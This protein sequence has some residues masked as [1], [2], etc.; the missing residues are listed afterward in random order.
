LLNY[1]HLY[2]FHVTATEGSVARAAERLDVGQ[3]TVS[4]QVR[5]L[6]RSLATPLFERTGGKLRLTDAGRQAYEHTSIMFRAGER[7]VKSLVGVKQP[8]PIT[9][10]VGI[11]VGVGRV[12]ATDLLKPLFALE[13]CVPSIRC[14]E[15]ADLLRELRSHDLDLLLSESDPG[16][17]ARPDMQ[18]VAIDHTR[19][20]AITSA[21]QDPQAS[22]A[23]S[24]LVHYRPSSP[25]RFAIDSYLDD[26]NLH[27]R[28]AAETDDALVML[29]AVV[30][31]GFLAFVPKAIAREAVASGKVRV[32]AQLAVDA[33]FYALYHD[34]ESSMIARH[35]VELLVDCARQLA[36]D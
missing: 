30:R 6:E 24:A 10:R 27:P 8:P 26:K 18:I 1:N 22:W 21:A 5:Q 16:E 29:A 13:D 12:V 3:P 17:R 20:V 35:A 4:E 14:G 11:G 7:L 23:D 33:P 32:L 2:Y 9:L 25:Y 34:V 36:D 19:L 28:V 15:A 31:G